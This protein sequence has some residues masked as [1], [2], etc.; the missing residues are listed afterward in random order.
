MNGLLL[1]VD[2]L[3]VQFDTRDGVV[4][5]VN[6]LTFTVGRGQTV[7]IVGESGSGKSATAQA[8]MGL[9]DP[10][11]SCIS[12]GSIRFQGR[13]LIG[14]RQREYRQLRGARMSMVFQDALSS[15]NPVINIGTQVAEM[16]TVHEGSSRAEAKR[17]AIEVLERVG[18]P[19]AA[20]RYGAYPH[21]FSGG[22]RQRIMIA[23]AIAL[24]PDLLIA[25]EPTTALDVTVQ[26]QI[27]DLLGSLQRETGMGVVLITHD[28]GVAATVAQRIVVMY[29]GRAMEYGDLAEVYASPANPYTRDLLDAVPR[30]DH[31]QGRLTSIPGS[32]PNLVHLPSGCAYHPRCRLASEICSLQAPPL[33]R[34]APNRQS[35][36]WFAAEVMAGER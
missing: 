32:P 21:Q 22:M 30:L 7:A 25:D 28:V 29:A 33:S 9:L 8:I 3:H 24:K 27:M 12:Q 4:R 15:L 2:G 17:Q 18:I 5:A 26:A 36:C 14:M 35:A 10:N 20:A 19:D 23:M 11:V 16:F 1:E 13:E 6:G 34:I 31:R